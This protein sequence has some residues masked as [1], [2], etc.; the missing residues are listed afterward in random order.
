MTEIIRLP[1]DKNGQAAYMGQDTGGRTFL[2]NLPD[3]IDT[4]EPFLAAYGSQE[5]VKYICLTRLALQDI[6]TLR[7]LSLSMGF[8]WIVSPLQR[9]ALFFLRRQAQRDGLCGFFDLVVRGPFKNGLQDLALKPTSQN[10]KNGSVWHFENNVFVGNQ[11]KVELRQLLAGACFR[12][13]FM[14][15]PPKGQC[16]ML[17]F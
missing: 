3:P 8:H 7:Y 9:K 1:E 10:E 2:V 13:E 17:A 15:Y 4:V 12:G 14:I 11:T 5:K 16:Y 6:P